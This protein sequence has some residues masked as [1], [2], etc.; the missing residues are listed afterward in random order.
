MPSSPPPPK[1]VWLGMEG[2]KV[3]EVEGQ[4]NIVVLPASYAR[5]WPC[6]PWP[7]MAIQILTYCP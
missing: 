5:L 3:V 6:P 4:R 2:E 7:Y 1:G